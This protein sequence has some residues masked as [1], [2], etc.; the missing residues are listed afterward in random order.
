MIYAIDRREHVEEACRRPPFPSLPGPPIALPRQADDLVAVV[1]KL[2]E[3]AR[4][5]SDLDDE[6]D[7]DDSLRE[8]NCTQEE[9]INVNQGKRVLP[10][11][12]SN[13]SI[14][15]LDQTQ[16]HEVSFLSF[17]SSAS[18]H[19]LHLSIDKRLAM[20]L[21]EPRRSLPH[22]CN[23]SIKRPMATRDLLKSE[24]A[25]REAQQREDSPFQI[26]VNV[27]PHMDEN[28]QLKCNAPEIRKYKKRFNCHILCAALWG[29]SLS[30]N[31]RMVGENWL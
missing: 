5:D 13:Q 31:R 30:F 6:T 21:N 15:L 11:L 18:F 17:S 12:L 7:L 27:S 16:S 4:N 10:D 24:R 3:L 28:E 2:N 22:R 26:D 1:E 25:F 20:S 14:H 9:F 29:L 8:I 19:S 23:I